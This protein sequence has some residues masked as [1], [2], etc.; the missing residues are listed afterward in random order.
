VE[1]AALLLIGPGP[2]TLVTRVNT[3]V[4]TTIPLTPVSR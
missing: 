2:P 4:Q 3:V 1:R